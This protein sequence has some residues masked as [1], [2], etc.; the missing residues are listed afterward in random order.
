MCLICIEFNKKKMTKEELKKA[1][2]EMIM[3]AKTPEE[4]K[5][6]EQLKELGDQ[7]NDDAL[8]AFTK[9]NTKNYVKKSYFV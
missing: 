7:G 3:F 2:P 5:H 9:D 8:D 4:Q 1:L 6:F